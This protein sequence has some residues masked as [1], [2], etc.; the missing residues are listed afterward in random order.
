MGRAHIGL[1]R[2]TYTVVTRGFTR[3][4]GGGKGGRGAGPPPHSHRPSAPSP[5]RPSPPLPTPHPHTPPH[6]HPIPSRP[7]LSTAPQGSVALLLGLVAGAGLFGY[8]YLTDP[9]HRIPRRLV[10]F[11]EDVFFQTLLPPIIFSAGG[12]SGRVVER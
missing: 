6:P 7:H 3:T 8:Y 5:Q 1:T 11:D 2:P 12:R 10:T 9:N 4:E